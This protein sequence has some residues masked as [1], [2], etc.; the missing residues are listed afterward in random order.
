MRLTRQSN[1][2]IRALVYCA[3][4]QPGL[5]RVA[6]IA[7]AYGI[8]ELFLFK[9]IKPL[10]E[11]GLIE[12]VRGRHGGIRLG[13]PAADITLLETIRLTEENF[14]LAECFEDGADCPLIGECDLN[15]ALREALGAFFTVLDGYTIAD[16]ASKKRSLRERLGLQVA[17]DEMAPAH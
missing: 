14:A 5:S 10:V 17:V 1:Y 16:L 9:L 4:N 13:K 7:R 2:A 11:N 15:G 8:S 12:T 6:D 3:V